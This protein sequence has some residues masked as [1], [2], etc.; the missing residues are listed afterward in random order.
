M[1]TFSY[2]LLLIDL[3]VVTRLIADKIYPPSGFVFNYILIDIIYLKFEVI[4]FGVIS[5]WE[6]VDVN[7]CIK[8]GLWMEVKTGIKR[9]KKSRTIRQRYRETGRQTYK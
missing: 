9:L 7:P 1:Q 6:R 5:K 2:R 8:T 4:D 3:F